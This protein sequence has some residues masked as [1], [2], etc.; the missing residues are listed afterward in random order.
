[1]SL[2]MAIVVSV[3][4]E[5]GGC[6]PGT[7]GLPCRLCSTVATET[8][9]DDD[10][11]DDDVHEL[12]SPSDD[13]LI[14]IV[15]RLKASSLYLEL[16]PL[17]SWTPA[18]ATSCS[19]TCQEAVE[20]VKSLEASP[21]AHT[22]PCLCPLMGLIMGT[23][24]SMLMLNFTLNLMSEHSAHMCAHMR[25]HT[26][27]QPHQVSSLRDSQPTILP[28]P[29]SAAEFYAEQLYRLGCKTAIEPDSSIA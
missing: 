27:P 13:T 18:A 4:K 14:A 6:G 15:Q 9:M 7:T 25:Q 2:G 3:L 19:A 17:A 23:F 26:G 5:H 10:D 8:L 1:M 29:C 28:C 24:H 22:P 16:P 11:D 12:A 20:I 21:L